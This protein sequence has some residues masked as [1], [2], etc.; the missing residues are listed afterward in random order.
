M[1]GKRRVLYDE[2]HTDRESVLNFTLTGAR[3]R[4]GWSSARIGGEATW[5]GG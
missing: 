5:A 1:E 4:V 2:Q 3:R